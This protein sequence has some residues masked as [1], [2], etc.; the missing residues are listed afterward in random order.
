MAIVE[1]LLPRYWDG[2]RLLQFLAGLALIALSFTL[3]STL[4]ADVV[5]A[6]AAPAPVSAAAPAPVSAAARAEASATETDQGEESAAV[7]GAD[8]IPVVAPAV[9][10]VEPARMLDREGRHDAAPRAPPFA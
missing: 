3:S 6:P 2:R 10:A 1:R 4:R 7:S 9:V 5:A 8:V